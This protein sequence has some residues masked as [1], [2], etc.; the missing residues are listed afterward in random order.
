MPD[1]ATVHI[2]D[3]DAAVRESLQ[4][5]MESVGIA[6]ETYDSAQAF[7]LESDKTDGGCLL[8]DVRLRDMS[9]LEL[10]RR[11]T[12]RGFRLPIIFITGHG[13]VN[14]AVQAMKNGAVDFV[15]KPFDDQKLL[16]T[17]Q[18]VLA[19]TRETSE[20]SARRDLLR[21]R[22]ASLSSRERQVLDRVVAGKLNKTIAGE[23]NISNKTV[24][25]HRARVM[26]KMGARNLAELVRQIALIDQ[27]H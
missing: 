1:G 14:M 4:W 26:D 20:K 6:A 25:V 11:L 8:L 27:D 17:V 18:R 12:E 21:R 23:L 10:Q 24:E 22:L 19:Q 9:G 7:L 16:D 2:V 3:D 13:E 5:L 15:T